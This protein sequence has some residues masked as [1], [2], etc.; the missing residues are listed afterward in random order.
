MAWTRTPA[1]STSARLHAINHPKRYALMML[2]ATALVAGMG[3]RFT[4]PRAAADTGDQT[5]ESGDY[6]ITLTPDNTLTILDK[7]TST[8]LKGTPDPSAGQISE[9]EIRTQAGNLTTQLRDTL[10]WDLALDND[11]L[12]LIHEVNTMHQKLDSIPQATL[13]LS[14]NT[15]IRTVRDIID[16]TY[17]TTEC[18]ERCLDSSA[19]FTIIAGGLVASSVRSIRDKMYQGE[20]ID[21]ATATMTILIVAVNS[22]AFWGYISETLDDPR[23]P[24]GMK[25]VLLL[26][27]GAIF[28]GV[29]RT[30]VDLIQYTAQSRKTVREDVTKAAER[31]HSLTP[32]TEPA[33]D[34]NLVKEEL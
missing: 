16:Q 20:Q 23:V 28:S 11:H 4:A 33:T 12:R 13:N 17:D 9:A 21:I 7:K 25:R 32:G 30:M 3:A 6:S 34:Y 19:V 5:F 26:L 10:G 2:V 1:R 31:V 18:R 8:A 22:A 14:E 24:E 15:D 29:A 27:T